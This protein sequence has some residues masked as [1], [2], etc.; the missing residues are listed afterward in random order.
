M[1]GRDNENPRREFLRKSLTLIP[2]VTVAST[3]IGMNAFASTPA[4][5]ASAPH[6]APDT[7]AAGQHF[8]AIHQ[9]L[10]RTDGSLQLLRVL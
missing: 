2:L 10:W 8:R 7:P 4:A 3:G 9:P 1:S 5:P 6:K